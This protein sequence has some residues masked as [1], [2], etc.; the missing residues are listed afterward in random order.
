MPLQILRI[1]AN[2]LTPILLFSS[3]IHKKESHNYRIWDLYG[4]TVRKILRQPIFHKGIHETA[5][6]ERIMLT[7]L[8]NQKDKRA[9]L[10]RTCP[11]VLVELAN[12]ARRELKNA[13]FAGRYSHKQ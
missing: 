12:S 13:R 1:H 8:N 5:P 2:A 10:A 9:G 11:E 4:V 6:I 7:S 3:R